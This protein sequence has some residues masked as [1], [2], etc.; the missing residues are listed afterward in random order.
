MVSIFHKLLA[1]AGLLDMRFHDLR[2]SAAT[3]LL[4]ASV[5]LKVVQERMGCSTIA[6]TKD[7]Y[8]HLSPSMQQKVAEKIDDMF[9]HL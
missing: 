5:Y 4:V 7:I 1:D 6:M 2:H 3:I 9:K 8:L